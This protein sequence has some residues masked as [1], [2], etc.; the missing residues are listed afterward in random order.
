MEHMQKLNP[1]STEWEIG[2]MNYLQKHE[3]FMPYSVSD[4]EID[5]H[6]KKLKG[7]L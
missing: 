3:H 1:F 5:E 7:E 2:T 6:L 4:F